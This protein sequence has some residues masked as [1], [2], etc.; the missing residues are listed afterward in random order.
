MHSTDLAI[1]K[2]EKVLRCY[3][4]LFFWLFTLSDFLFFLSFAPELI[5]TDMQIK[6]SATTRALKSVRLANPWPG[7]FIFS[8]EVNLDNLP[9][10]RQGTH[11][12]WQPLTAVISNGPGVHP[13]P[14]HCDLCVCLVCF[15]SVK[16]LWSMWHWVLFK[17][18]LLHDGFGSH[19]LLPCDDYEC[20]I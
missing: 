7:G 16:P 15:N 8:T 17:C 12:E 13:K 5:W 11:P 4:L 18:F 6:E 3:L 2:H 10:A 9:P 14:R 19:V 20:L 1:N